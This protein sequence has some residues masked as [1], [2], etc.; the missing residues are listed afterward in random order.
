MGGCGGMGGGQ[1]VLISHFLEDATFQSIY[2]DKLKVVYEEVF[3]SDILETMVNQYSYLI[4]SANLERNLV[5]LDAHDQAV[6]ELLKFIVECKEYL[7][8]HSQLME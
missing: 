4:H 5:D 1:N 2:E 8:S 7:R 6:A 3:L